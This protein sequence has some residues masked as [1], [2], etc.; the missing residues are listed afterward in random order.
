MSFDGIVTRAV[1]HELIT[2]LIGGRISK[3]YQP[4]D[5]ELMLYIRSQ[6]QNHKLY[7][8]AHPAYPRFQFT[9]SPVDHP[10]EPPMFCMLLRKHMEGSLIQAIRQVGMER[11]VQ[12]DI[13]GVNELG[14]EVL[15]RLSIE[16]LGRTSNVI[17]LDLETNRIMDALRRVP[18]S[19][20]KVRPVLPGRDYEYPPAQEKLDPFEVDET[21]FLSGFDYLA[22]RLD[23]QL[24]NR[25]LG[26]GPLVAKEIVFRAGIGDRKNLWNAFHQL[27]EEFRTHQYQPTRVEVEGRHYFYGTELTHLSGEYLHFET[28]SECLDSFYY[29]KADRDRIRG[30]TLDLIKRLTNELEK[31]EKKIEILR[32]EVAESDLV[33][34]ERIKG[35]L[36]TTYMHELQRGDSF[37]RLVNYYDPEEKQIEIQLDPLLSPSENAQRYYKRYNKRKASKKYNLEQIAI[38]QEEIQYL[39]SVLVLLENSSLKEV[40]QIREELEEECWIR[41]QRRPNRKKKE[42]PNPISM[43]AKDGTLILVGKN[44]KQ[45]DYLTHQLAHNSDTWLHTKDIPGSH[46]VIRSKEISEETLLEAATLAAYYSKARE[47]SQVPVDYV[48]IKHVKKPAGARPGFVIYENQQTLYVTPDE[49]IVREM[50]KRTKPKAH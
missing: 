27:I 19:V 38:A 39:E 9:E 12:I 44:N 16:I 24:V 50:L 33:E 29:G 30:Q 41:T 25:F 22:G 1:T 42:K 31:N 46:V 20:S 37:V 5:T 21:T 43:Y 45:N 34:E 28:M 11:I 8:S 49:N 3:I 15:R 2:K 18:Y 10:K 17:L 7:I 32:K 4:S 35:E 48:T 47:S 36:L 14:D 13:R 26:L 40:E 23:K 6:G